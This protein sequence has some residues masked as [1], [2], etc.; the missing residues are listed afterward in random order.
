[1]VPEIE[2]PEDWTFD[3]VPV[4]EE[5]LVGT[6]LDFA[7]INKHYH[8]RVPPEHSTINADFLLGFILHAK[9]DAYFAAEYMAEIVTS[10]ISSSI[11]NRTLTQILSTR[12]KN[13]NQIEFFQQVHLNNA[14]AVREA[15]N[16]GERSF[17]D[18]IE[19]L[20]RADRFKKWLGD[21]NPDG[22]L[23]EEYYRAVTA[24]SWIEKLPT[25]SLRFVF[26]TAGG[27]AADLFLPTGGLGMA[28]GA[29]LGAVDSLLLD[30]LLKGWKP[31]QFVEGEGREFTSGR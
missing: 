26:T 4:G 1:L 21:R 28:V 12:Q 20:S 15:I 6:N 24:Y 31:N 17:A 23:L 9:A 25:K 8:K 3:V 30:R 7:E 10:P 11:I 14:R 13:L 27:V 19:L 5:F 22:T 18:F 29:G 16:S 2:L